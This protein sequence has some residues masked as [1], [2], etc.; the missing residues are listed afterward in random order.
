MEFYVGSGFR[1]VADTMAIAKHA[2]RLGYGGFALPDHVF[3]PVEPTTPYPYTDSGRP[4]F[5]LDSPFPDVWVMIGTLGALTTRIRIRTNVLVLPL[6]HPVAVAKAVGTAAVA[7]GGRVELGVGVGHLKDEF[8]VLGA[9]F[10]TR[11]RRTD[12]AI[13]ALRSLLQPGP[14]SYAGEFWDIPPIYLHPA[15]QQ[16][17]PILI[18]GESDAALRRAARLGDGYVS[19]PRTM[20]ELDELVTGLK[21][22]RQELA[23]E[24]PPLRF[25]LDCHDARTVGDYR[26]LA[27]MGADVVKIDSREPA[28]ATLDERV[29]ILERFADA[30]ITK[31]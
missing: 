7:T 14:V 3:Y 26:R 13:R 24:M 8:D 11:G 16:P 23:P 4:T 21:K 12:E 6:R 20:D 10:G 15:P 9:D 27:D 25:H 28:G 31:L 1:P 18:G 29:E 19:V 5:A 30:I 17:V 22:S 2:E